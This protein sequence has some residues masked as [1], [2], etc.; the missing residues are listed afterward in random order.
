MA[1]YRAVYTLQVERDNEMN[2]SHRIALVG[3]GYLGKSLLRK[4]TSLNVLTKFF[5]VACDS[6]SK[7]DP[8]YPNAAGFDKIEALPGYTT[9]LAAAM[10]TLT[11]IHVG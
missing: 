2:A 11:A 5:G 7:I 10:A 8:Q 6:R 4:F 3:V 9:I 1:K